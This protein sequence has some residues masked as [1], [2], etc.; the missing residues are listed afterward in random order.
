[1]PK[2]N[3]KVLLIEPDYN[4]A[5]SYI[6]ALN[7]QSMI[8]VNEHDVEIAISKLDVIQPQVIILELQLKGHNGI[9]FLHEFRSYAD[10]QEIPIVINSVIP[11]EESGLTKAIQ[12]KLGISD[13]CYKPQTSVLQLGNIIKGLVK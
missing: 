5:R 1:M 2:Q 7:A 4:L 6:C 13:Y 11:E 8:C 12:K 9:E 3:K 10:W